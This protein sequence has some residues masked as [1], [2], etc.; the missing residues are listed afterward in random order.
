MRLMRSQNWQRARLHWL[1]M[2]LSFC[3]LNC[4]RL[5]VPAST[6]PPAG[7][8]SVEEFAHQ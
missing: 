7:S 2:S 8:G 1:V 3:G 5:R 6:G 4:T